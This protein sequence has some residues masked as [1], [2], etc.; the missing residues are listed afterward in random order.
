LR[1]FNSSTTFSLG[2]EEGIK[3]GFRSLREIAFILAE[4]YCYLPTKRANAEKVPGYF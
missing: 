2:I 1:G 3:E 4:I